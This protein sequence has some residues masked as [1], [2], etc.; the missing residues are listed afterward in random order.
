MKR[1]ETALFSF[2]PNFCLL[3]SEPD[4]S[5]FFKEEDLNSNINFNLYANVLIVHILEYEGETALKSQIKNFSIS[6]GI[7]FVSSS[8]TDL[9]HLPMKGEI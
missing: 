7:R 2:L 1:I 8:Q 3:Y 4:K 5:I 6:N 9:L